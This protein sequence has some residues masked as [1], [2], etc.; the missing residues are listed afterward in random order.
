MSKQYQI[1]HRRFGDSRPG[2]ELVGIEEAAVPV[3]VLRADVLAQERKDLP[4]TEAFT[5]QFVERHV[6]SPHRMPKVIS[7]E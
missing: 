4:V 7:A 5:L 3:T 1:L 2:L 6:D